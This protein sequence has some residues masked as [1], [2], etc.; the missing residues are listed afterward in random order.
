MKGK[1]ED[2]ISLK[3]AAEITGYSSDYVGQLIRSGKLPGKQI[4]T[5]VSWVTTREAL[6]E[7]HR[8]DKKGKMAQAIETPTITEKLLS[9]HGLLKMYSFVGWLAVFLLT[10]CF[11]FL[12]YMVSVSID[13]RI[14]AN[15]L[16]NIEYAR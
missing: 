4:F 8:K 14:N 15:Y 7:Y 2:Y 10:I 13:H 6:L 3:E 16:E 1:N 5:N 12:V 11:F 9:P